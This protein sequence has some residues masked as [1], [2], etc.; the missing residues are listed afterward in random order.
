KERKRGGK[1]KSK[2]KTEEGGEEGKKRKAKQIAADIISRGKK[3]DFDS[4]SEEEKQQVTFVQFHPSYDYSDFVEGLRPKLNSDG[5]MG[6]ELIDGI[7]KEFVNQARVNYEASQKSLEVFQK[8]IDA[9]E[10]ISDFFDNLEF[11]EQEFSILRG[12][13]FFI[14]DVDEKYIYIEIPENKISNE[15]KLSLEQLKLMLQSDKTFEKVLDI[16]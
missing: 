4:L 13:K 12:S 16:K 5:T 3:H 9:Q 11:G 7:F 14:T 10:L 1:R 8:E 2:K 15:L 6:F